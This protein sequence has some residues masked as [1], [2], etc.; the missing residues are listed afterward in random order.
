V[1]SRFHDPLET[2]LEMSQASGIRSSLAT[3]SSSGESI[4][5]EPDGSARSLSRGRPGLIE[6][7]S[8][9]DSLEARIPAEEIQRR[10]ERLSLDRDALWGCVN[11]NER[12]YQR[13]LIHF[14]AAYEVLV[15]CWRSE[16]R[17]PI[18]DHADSACGVLVVG[19]A[20]E[21]SFAARPARPL[22]AARARRVAAGCVV[23]SRGSDIHQVANLEPSAADLI[24][25]HVYSRR[26]SASRYFR[27]DQRQLVHEAHI[28]I[29][30]P[31][32]ILARL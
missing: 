1:K 2:H 7:L 18:H 16:Q 28:S 6:L 9:W 17:S 3:N 27:T 10:L 8:G 31:E 21:T 22:I 4:D 25:L 29:P 11:F 30:F 19:V 32:T 5:M 23:V 13:N 20:T 15:L 24:S 12:A 26:L 14:T